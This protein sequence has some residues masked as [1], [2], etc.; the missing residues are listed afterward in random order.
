VLGIRIE[1]FDAR[2]RTFLAPY[3]VFLNRPEGERGGWRVHRHTVPACVGLRGLVERHLPAGNGRDDEGG[4][5]RKQDLGRFA[6]AVRRELVGRQKRFEAVA[7]LRED[8]GLDKQGAG[9]VGELRAIRETDVSAREIGIEWK[10]GTFGEVRLRKDGTIEK[11]SVR[12]TSSQTANGN[13]RRKGNLETKIMA[14][15]GRVEGIVQRL[16]GV[17]QLA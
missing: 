5:Q 12:K 9:G 16:L 15:D 1:V 3:H 2:A 10:D 11:A 17:D 13:S 8:A 4:E 7:K 14:G 6:R